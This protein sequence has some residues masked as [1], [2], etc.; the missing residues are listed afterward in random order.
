[1]T[2]NFSDNN[3]L[4]NHLKKGDKKAYAYLVKSY[5]QK[6]SVY[7]NSLMN[8]AYLTEDIVQNVFIKIWERRSS[9]N[10]EL[11]IQSFLYKLAYNEFIDQY[12]KKQSLTI[13]E[14]KYMETINFVVSE[15]NQESL[16]TL[17]KK[18]MSVIEVLPPKCK[19][20]FLL[21]KREGLTNIEIA[22]YLGVS[23]KAVEKQITKAFA[24]IRE[25][26]GDRTNNLLFL[27]FDFKRT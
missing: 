6:L 1:M 24:I 21:S 3:T 20:I 5:H 26:I 9:L 16:D 2:I 19:H 14:K 7:I 23:I 13:V 18:V 10:P 15:D 22:E 17:M 27:L 25:K 11:S 8:D 4:A 12:R